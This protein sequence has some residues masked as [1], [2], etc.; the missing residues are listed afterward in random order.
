MTSDAH[1]LAQRFLAF[2]NASPSPFHAVEECRRT[3]LASSFIEL[4]E[5]EAWSLKPDSK[6]FFTR[7]RS[8]LIAFTVGGKFVPGTKSGFSIVGAHTDSP[9]LR[10]KPVSE[11]SK[12]GYV[13]LGVECYGGGLWHT[14]FDRDLT[15]AGRAIV[16]AVDGQLQHR[17]VHIKR[18]ILRV[19]TLAIH[20]NREVN[21]DGFKFNT[22]TQLVPMLATAVKSR[23]E[24]TKGDDG[25]RRAGVE[26]KHHST[27]LK[28][29][30]EELE[31]SVDTIVDFELCLA[32]TQPSAIGGLENE[33]IFSPRLDNLMSTF[34]ALEALVT[35][36]NAPGSLASDTSAR[37]IS[38]FDHE[39]IGSRS[40]QGADSAVMESTLR[41]IV[42]NVES[43]KDQRDTAFQETV[44]HS[45]LVSA[46]MA[47]AVHP[48]YSDKHEENHR[49]VIHGGPVIKSNANQRYATNSVSGTVIREIARKHNIPVQEF[50][51]RNDSACGSTIGPIVAGN[52]GMRTIDI[53]NP[54]L[55]MHSIRETCG[56][57]DVTYAVQLI[58]AFFE[59]FPAMDARL[60]VD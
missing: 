4:K 3:L 50:V 41:R 59:D 14:W 1:Q 54:Q 57:D 35:S 52:L 56:V 42:S 26:G 28:L 11:L 34:C 15:V 43:N 10:V 60:D 19:P 8:T 49:P 16:R 21:S 5:K 45:L 6:Y 25:K 36:S 30:S 47:H 27:F 12:A 7:N 37:I 58:K 38:L 2:V 33:F 44:A 22:E 53:G 29:L 23:L 24:K 17:L 13:S 46:D 40:A 51:V 20:L 39:E 18:P 9:C 31:C 32:D 55:S 48:N